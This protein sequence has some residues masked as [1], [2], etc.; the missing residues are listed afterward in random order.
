[1][2]I[3]PPALKPL[4]LIH[5]IHHSEYGVRGGLIFTKSVESASRLVRLLEYF[6]EAWLEE[7]VVVRGYTSEMKP[8]ERK[9]LLAE[10]AEGKVTL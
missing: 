3:L 6:E 10:F 1:M 5:L 9:R 8:A 7:R 4:N 2:L